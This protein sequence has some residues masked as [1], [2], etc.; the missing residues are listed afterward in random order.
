[1]KKLLLIIASVA[2]FGLSNAFSQVCTAN[3][4]CLP[5][6]AQYGLC[7]DS[8]TGIAKGCINV[9]YNQVVSMKVPANAG[10]FGQPAS[11]L[12]DYIRIDSVVNL[13]PGLT[14]ACNPS[15]NKFQESSNGC[16]LISGTPTQVWN[17]QI[18]VHATARVLV[19]VVVPVN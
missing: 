18:T 16:I 19:F 1:M 13:A 7:P 4:S 2:T 11:T 15:D 12:I 6:G 9:P 17:K 8:T 10:A 14:W 5:S 3:V